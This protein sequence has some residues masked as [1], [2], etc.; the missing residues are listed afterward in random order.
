MARSSAAIQSVGADKVLGGSLGEISSGIERGPARISP[1]DSSFSSR[2]LSSF[3]AENK[4]K[5]TLS[6]ARPGKTNL[7]VLELLQKFNLPAANEYQSRSLSKINLIK[8]NPANDYEY[9]LRAISAKKINYRGLS[10][11]Y[12]NQP[13]FIS[14]PESL[15]KKVNP[16]ESKFKKTL[17]NPVD[18][19][20]FITSHLNLKTPS[21]DYENPKKISFD[22]RAQGKIPEIKQI[23][24]PGEQKSVNYIKKLPESLLFSSDHANDYRKEPSFIFGN[25]ISTQNKILESLST[26]QK[27]EPVIQKSSAMEN[28]VIINDVARE[29]EKKSAQPNISAKSILPPQSNNIVEEDILRI[30]KIRKELDLLILNNNLKSEVHPEIQKA[31]NIEIES[32]TF[33]NPSVKKAPN[34]E[35]LTIEQIREELRKINQ[36]TD[37]E[38]AR[39]KDSSAALSLVKSAQPSEKEPSSEKKPKKDPDYPI[40]AQEVKELRAKLALS[41]AKLLSET[42]ANTVSQQI[43]IRLPDAPKEAKSPIAKEKGDGSYGEF[44]QQLERQVFPS[45]SQAESEIRKANDNNNPVA[46]AKNGEEASIQEVE[47]VLSGDQSSPQKDY[48]HPAIFQ[49]DTKLN[50]SEE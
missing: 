33:R 34:P 46:I 28:L 38:E 23:S 20:G 4:N 6:A 1:L 47:K 44:R 21:N 36:A 2:G 17:D 10:G 26:K 49:K 18:K 45:I 9:P 8:Q 5:S 41:S 14:K 25:T 48:E 50:Y 29:H 30:K 37:K 24:K 3:R 27:L 31:K 19:I 39:E 15:N 22:L 35:I 12:L 40:V 32:A 42:D 43:I 16:N 13:E 11:R 7:G